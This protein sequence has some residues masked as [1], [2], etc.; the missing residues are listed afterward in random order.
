MMEIGPSGREA[1]ITETAT[2]RPHRIE[3]GQAMRGRTTLSGA[4]LS[5]ASVALFTL[6]GCAREATGP[7]EGA[8]ALER[9]ASAPEIAEPAEIQL[10][11]TAF[12]PGGPIPANYTEDGDDVSPPLSWSGVPEGTKELALICDDPD[13][14]SPEHPGP[15]PWVHW[16]IYK[17]PAD[18]TGLSEGI[19][20]RPGLTTRPG[21]FKAKTPGRRSGIGARP[22]R[23]EAARTATCSSSTLWTR[24]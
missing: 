17:I 8:G 5:L 12:E 23:A 21:R 14:P 10:T 22:R 7:S 2:G 24:S 15:D 18:A 20:R 19:P 4:R 13:A 11:S 1:T 16:V 3:W 6:A 9:P